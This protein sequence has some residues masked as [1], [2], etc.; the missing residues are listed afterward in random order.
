MN[1]TALSGRQGRK[2]QGIE[3]RQFLQTGVALAT[4]AATG[5]GLLTRAA[6]AEPGEAVTP[7]KVAVPST[8]IA[9]LHKRLSLVRWPTAETVPN[10]SQGVP[11]ARMKALVDYW[12]HGYD[13]R[14]FEGQINRLPQFRT[15]IDGLGIHFI[16]VRSPHAEATPLLLTHGWPGSVVEFMKVIEPLTNPSAHG[17]RAEDAFHLVIP[18]LPGFGFSDAPTAPGWNMARVA[19]AWGV[20]MQR[21][22]Y[23]RFVAQGGDW[24]AAVTTWMAKLQVPGLAAIRLNL[25][26][27]FP[28]PIQGQPTDEEKKALGQLQ[29][30]RDELGAYAA[31]MRTRPQTIGYALND[32]PVAQAAWIYE[33]FIEWTD[34][35]GDP[36]SV[37]SRDA[38]LDDISLYWFTRTGISSARMYFESFGKDFSAQKL[39]IPVAVSLF[40]GE[41]FQP[42]KVWGERMYSRLVYWNVAPRGGH[43]AALE[44]PELF[45]SELRNAFAAAH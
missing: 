20:L 14:R 40:P 43:F 10:P 18:S 44:Q 37:I 5:V 26:L 21:L 15:T 12:Q 29:R 27:L 24:G 23:T 19:K 34:S 30:Y 4:V 36:E 32:S 1:S 9:D 16:H 3:R 25:P 6:A 7:F 41:F 38:I 45:A 17:G 11:L 31:V 2:S 42:P 35:K 13:W 22:G 39:D 8:D 33:K 28:P